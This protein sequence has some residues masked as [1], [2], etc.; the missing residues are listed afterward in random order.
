VTSMGIQT[1]QG[2]W[3]HVKRFRI[4]YSND[5]V[6]FNYLHRL[7]YGIAVSSEIDT[8]LHY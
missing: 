5:G 1:K 8:L 4:S 2:A 6:S 3:E 7:N